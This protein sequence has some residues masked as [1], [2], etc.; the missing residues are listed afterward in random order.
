MS[1]TPAGH[2][3]GYVDA[4]RN[5]IRQCWSAMQG[6]MNDYPSFRDGLRGVRLVEAAAD[7]ARTRRSVDTSHA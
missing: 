4:F 7:S 2:A 1:N 6:G 5:V 3:E